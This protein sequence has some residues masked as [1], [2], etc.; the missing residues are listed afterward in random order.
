MKESSKIVPCPY[1]E[2]GCCFCDYSSRIRIGD[3]EEISEDTYKILIE[4]RD[5]I[6]NDREINPV[7]DEQN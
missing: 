2:E 6:L 7:S 5:E 4:T 3:E 1:C